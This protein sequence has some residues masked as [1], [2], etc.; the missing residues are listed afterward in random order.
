MSGPR[1]VARG[2]VG[3]Y[4]DRG[5]VIKDNEQISQWQDQENDSLTKDETA[6]SENTAA[7]MA[8]KDGSATEADNLVNVNDQ[9]NFDFG[10]A[11]LKP[12]A[13]EKLKALGMQLA[14]KPETQV[15]IEGYADSVGDTTANI[16]LS[17]ARARAVR[18]ALVDSG[19]KAN[20][21]VTYGY[22]E[23]N[24]VASNT[25]PAGRAQNRRVEI[26]LG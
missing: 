8:G 23:N 13:V 10:M 5:S 22:G 16:A 19:V 14:Q 20:Q 3:N 9:L 21:V 18:N 25:S 12:D 24:P 15:R 26:H 6:P 2:G 7:E 11:A 4:V 1:S 17:K